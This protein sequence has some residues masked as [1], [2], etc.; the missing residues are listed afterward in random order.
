MTKGKCKR[1][2]NTCSIF[3][4]LK[5]LIPLRQLQNWDAQQ[6]RPFEPFC[7]PAPEPYSPRVCAR[8]A[9]LW[10]LRGWQTGSKSSIF[11]GAG[12]VNKRFAGLAGFFSCEA[13]DAIA[14]KPL[15]QIRDQFKS[16]FF[17]N[18]KV[19]TS[20]DPIEQV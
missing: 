18:F 11:L 9:G 3:G 10:P 2:G 19:G 12:L 14:C 15:L 6:N 16:S 4:Y 7:H 1:S 8:G 13:G 5:L 17:R 20:L